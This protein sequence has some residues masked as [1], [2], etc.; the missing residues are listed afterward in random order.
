MT[1]YTKNGIRFALLLGFVCGML[2]GIS[3]TMLLQA[4]Y[5]TPEIQLNT[6][7]KSYGQMLVIRGYGFTPDTEYTIKLVTPNNFELILQTGLTKDEIGITH[8]IEFD[9]MKGTYQVIIETNIGEKA[10]ID[11][12]FDQEI[13]PAYKE[14]VES[15]TPYGGNVA[16]EINKAENVTQAAEIEIEKI[17]TKEIPSWVKEVF[18]MWASDQISDQELLNGIR[19]LV[20]INVIIV[21]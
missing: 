17:Q 7:D 4:A 21:S 19:Y 6:I 18:K 15:N 8:P 2:F 5:A 9:A 1:E 11:F 20:N 10:I 12:N 3:I 16:P 13:T 14:F